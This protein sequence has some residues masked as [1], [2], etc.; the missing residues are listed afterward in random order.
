MLNGRRTIVLS[1]SHWIKLASVAGAL[2]LLLGTSVMSYRTVRALID[3]QVSV[4]HSQN[5]IDGIDR[6]VSL[7]RDAEIGA[8]TYVLTADARDLDRYRDGVARALDQ[9]GALRILVRDN[10]F[11][12]SRLDAL[13]PMLRARFDFLETLVTRRS[14][15][16]GPAE[17]AD[18]LQPSPDERSRMRGLVSAMADEETDLYQAQRERAATKASRTLWIIIIATGAG[19]TTICAI[20]IWV[21]W[22]MRMRQMAEGALRTANAT[23]EDRVRLRTEELSRSHL[24]LQELQSEL[25]H[26]G[27]VGA[28][29][30]MASTL[31]HE[32]NQPLAAIANYLAAAGKLLHLGDVGIGSAREALDRAGEQTRRAAEIIR[33]A[34]DFVRKRELHQVPESLSLV[35]EEATSLIKGAAYQH[36]VNLRLDLDSRANAAVVDRIQIQQVIIN[37]ARNAIEAMAGCERRELIISSELQPNGAVEIR[38]ADSGS[39]LSESVAEQL[40]QPFVTSKANGMGVGLSI[41]RT[42]VEAHG[43]AIWFETNRGGGAVFVFTVPSAAAVDCMPLAAA[44]SA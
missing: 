23:L 19:F 4:E 24:R 29:G 33:R 9:L 8:R 10:T 42:I 41:C 36:Q 1:R 18:S 7:L 16:A 12:S 27:R 30:Q 2:L 6:L 28:M 25:L 38:V 5:I 37:L 21:A 32:I 39:G 31:A 3:V 14:L 34:R 15:G 44:A 40:F 17:L 43:G 13:E 26:V 20:A 22:E 35:I 11:Q